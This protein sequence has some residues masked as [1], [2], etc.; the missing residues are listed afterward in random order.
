MINL[1]TTIVLTAGATFLFV[2][3][4]AMTANGFLPNQPAQRDDSLISNAH[5]PAARGAAVLQPVR[6]PARRH[7]RHGDRVRRHLPG[8]RGRDRLRRR[9]QRQHRRPGLRRRP[10]TRSGRA[11][12][13]A[14]LV[15]AVLLVILS[16]QLV[17]PT[18]RWR[19]RRHRRRRRRRRPC[20][21]RCSLMARLPRGRAPRAQ[22]PRPRPRAIVP[23][24]PGDARAS[25]SIPALVDAAGRARR[26]IAGGCGCGASVRR[27]WYVLAAR[28]G[29][30]ARA[31]DRACASAPLEWAPLARRR[32]ADRSGSSCCSCSSS[33][34]GPS[35]GE[36]ALAVD[37]EGGSG[38]RAG[39]GAR[40]RRRRCP[41]DRGAGGATTT[42]RRSWSA[43]GFE[44]GAAEARFVRRQR[45]DAVGRL[46]TIEPGP[47]PAAPRASGPRWS[48]SSPALLAHPGGAAAEPAGRRDRAEPAGPRGGAAAGGA[49]RRGRE[50]P[51]GQGRRRQRPADAPVRGA[52]P[53]RRAAARRTRAT[54]T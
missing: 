34:P 12:V 21:R 17:A 2:F 50:G 54:S 9:G 24:D 45:R 10:A 25:R 40:V 11:S 37:A 3:W 28:G 49:H 19:I 8:H 43:T 29:R 31:R 39:V 46:R 38:R 18:R 26:A 47:V 6:R 48:R 14:M 51:R 42:T 22:R 33:A 20:S 44:L 7:L 5:A 1:V 35:I 30:R 32:R 15:A 53:A 52:A 23:A 27:A 4:S 16:V 13:A 36:T 41:A